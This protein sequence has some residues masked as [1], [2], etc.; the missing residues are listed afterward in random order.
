[1]SMLDGAAP[2]A[3]PRP[4]SD[5]CEE[6]L[7]M[8]AGWQRLAELVR[9]DAELRLHL[10]LRPPRDLSADLGDGPQPTHPRASDQ[11]R[12]VSPA[13]LLDR[14]A[15]DERTLLE[16]VIANQ[17]EPMDALDFV[18]EHFV[19]PLVAV[20]RAL[21]DRHGLLLDLDTDHIRFE[22]T[23]GVR[24]T[25]RL[26]LTSVAGLRETAEVD[27]LEVSRAARA[28]HGGLNTLA[29][30]FQQATF[31]GRQYK[32]RAVRAAVE[33]VLSAELRYLA[34]ET[35]A[36]LRGDHPLDRYVHSVPEE[37]DR[38]LRDVLR[39][40]EESSAARRRDPSLPVPAVVIDLDL[41]G[42]VPK[43][44]T[45]HAART[46]AGPREGAPQGIPELARPGT[47]RALPSYSK[48]AWDRFL[49][50]SGVAGRYPDVEWD[51][52]HAEFCPAFY[53]PWERLRSDS[54]A[55]GLVRFVRDVEDAG[56][57]V[58]FN[59][60]RRDRVREHTSAVLARGGL[61]HVRLLTLPDDRVRPIAELKV[62][63]LRRLGDLDVVAVFDDLTENRQVLRDSFPNAMVV[64]VEAP[65]FVSDRVP[66]CPP[67]DGAPL[68]ATFERLPRQAGG[69]TP[70]LSHT[71][72]IAELQVGELSVGLPAR[73]HAVN[74][75]VAQTLSIVDRLVAEADS[76]A[77]RTAA[78]APG[79]LRAALSTVADPLER[80]ALLLH[81]VFMRK[82]FHRGS[83]GTYTP[84]MARKDLMPFLRY[85]QPIQVVVPGFPV[86]QSQSGLKATGVLPDLAELG[87]LVRLRE[88]QQTVKC[89]YAPGLRITVLTDGHH[90]RPR[91]AVIVE[92][93]LRKLNQYLRLVGGQDFLEFADIDDVARRRIGSSLDSERIV[94]IEYFQNTFRK[95]FTE[96]D[97]AADPM[98]V[99]SR[100]SDVDP[101]AE[102]T[103][104]GLAFRDMFRSILH[105]VA[106][107]VPAGRDRMSWARAVYTDPYQMGDPATPA[108]I[109]RARRQV[110]R[111][112]WS[113]TVR[114]L[115]AVLTD[116]ELGYDSLFT[117][118]VRLT[119][120]M[121]SPGRV[122]FAALG[123][124]ALL[125]WHGTAAVDEKGTLST[126][127]AIWL[128]DQ[129]FVPVYSPVLG[130]RQPWLMAPVTSTAV[131]DSS[132]G[133]QLIPELLEG[134]H[135]RR[136]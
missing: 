131:V 66:G 85:N 110:L 82:Q 64:A 119:V 39:A 59:T 116:R 26:V 80:T 133:A 134:I 36:L 58:V 13:A 31:D 114:Y 47:L 98:G 7:A 69:S 34:P 46:L 75:S 60:G 103:P 2:Q 95:A 25:G 52:V 41:C 88:L 94:L 96:L 130:Y 136:K 61:T 125:P 11:V 23:P 35:A 120:S 128:Y 93:Y 115:S 9:R 1:M 37:Q 68:I 21:V 6:H 122:G 121:P 51:D 38:L 112:A 5:G 117:H 8:A 3:V 63:N 18:A 43:A 100:V 28:L 126:D 99:L 105:S 56:G 77:Q 90:F 123:G 87:V 33:S 97:I 118:R 129:G 91:P 65:G 73:G 29:A 30:G 40:V 49:E 50:V 127:F 135:L 55:P 19:R 70:A 54:L 14:A 86:K 42:L 53:R 106:L 92:S 15:D 74:L 4:V 78:A 62:E 104:G 124:S 32:G 12:I 132:R 57:E 101:M 102:H 81:H 71:H 89:L 79:H 16:Q 44:R 20:W 84:E 48:P 108:E 76:N 67:P 109:V 107:D 111:Q 45:L 83:R 72:S 27:A 10:A 113:D 17:H 24:A 22:L